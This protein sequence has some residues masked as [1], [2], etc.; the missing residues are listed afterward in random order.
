MNNFI[1]NSA[2]SNYGGGAIYAVLPSMEPTSS[3][4]THQTILAVVRLLQEQ[5]IIGA[6]NFSLN[7][8]HYE[9]GVVLEAIYA[10]D[11]VWGRD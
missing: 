4:A 6:S 11:E 10:P 9:G 7:S 3:S 8:V 2:R 1:N 5:H